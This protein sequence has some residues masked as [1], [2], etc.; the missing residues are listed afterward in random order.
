MCRCDEFLTPL[1][2]Q[3]SSCYSWRTTGFVPF[4]RNSFSIPV[5]NL[6][7]FFINE[8]NSLLL[9]IIFFYFFLF[10]KTQLIN[11]FSIKVEEISL[12]Y[13]QKLH[14]FLK[15]EFN[16]TLK[17]LYFCILYNQHKIFYNNKNLIFAVQFD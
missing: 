11:N 14:F 15:V 10:I 9:I 8:L 6:F 3:R 12:F 13:I 1:M 4:N 5:R 17:K 16:C 2:P 7:L